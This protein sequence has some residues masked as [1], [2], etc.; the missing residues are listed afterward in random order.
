MIKPR[1]PSKPSKPRK[2]H[3]KEYI[4]NEIVYVTLE[5]LLSRN[6]FT[7]DQLIDDVKKQ[8]SDQEKLF[9]IFN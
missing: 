2:P 4:E 6:S 1:K 5:S 8:F 7:V 9:E 3:D